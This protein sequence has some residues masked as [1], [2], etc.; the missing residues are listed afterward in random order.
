MQRKTSKITYAT[1]A[2]LKEALSLKEL[3]KMSF[4][5]ISIKWQKSVKTEQSVKIYFFENL[6]LLKS[7]NVELTKV[8]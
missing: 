3:K 8:R 6:L 2:T 4:R 5:G 7:K 1:V